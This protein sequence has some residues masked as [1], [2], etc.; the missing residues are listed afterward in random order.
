MKNYRVSINTTRTR[1]QEKNMQ[2]VGSVQATS[3]SE[4][5]EKVYAAFWGKDNDSVIRTD[6]SDLVGP[7][8]K[9]KLVATID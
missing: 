3:K 5:I 8:T 7:S 4:A 2:E 1:F 6:M 9:S